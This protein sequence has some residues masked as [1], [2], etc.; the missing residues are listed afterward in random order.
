MKYRSGPLALVLLLMV[1]VAV[2]AGAAQEVP[3]GGAPADLLKLDF[4]SFKDSSEIPTWTGK[5][6]KLVVWDAFGTA[7]S[8]RI[9]SAGDVV[10]PEITRIT[11][12]S[13]DAEKSFNNAGDS[14]PVKLGKIVASGNWPHLITCPDRNQLARMIDE[15]LLWDLTDLVSQNCPNLA[16]NFPREKIAGWW[17]NSWVNGGK[18]GM[19]YGLP[20]AIQ[21]KWQPYIDA[22]LDLAKWSTLPMAKPQDPSTF[23]WVR[24]DILK[25]IFPN[26]RSVAEIEDLYVKRNGRFTRQDILDVPINSKEDFIKFLYDIKKLDVR[27]GNREVFPIFTLQG[28]IDNWALLVY[29]GGLFGWN[30]G[31]PSADANYFTYWDRKAQKVQY[32]FTQGFFKEAMRTFTQLVKDQVASPEALIDNDTQFREKLDNGMYA[33]SYAWFEPNKAVLERAG[34]PYRYRKVYLNIPQDTSRFGYTMGT[35]DDGMGVAMMVKKTVSEEDVRQILHYYDLLSSEVGWKL[36]SWGPKTAGLWEE[37]DGKRF[38]KDKDLEACM[39]YNVENERDIYYHLFRGMN[40][41]KFT[42]VDPLYPAV[43]SRWVPSV[44]YDREVKAS[45]AMND[46]ALGVPSPMK[47][48]PGT[49]PNIWLFFGA[50]PEVDRFWAARSAFEKGLIKIQTAENDAQFEQYFNEMV[51]L[52]QRNGM[53]AQT[54]EQI[55]KVYKENIN[56]AFMQNLK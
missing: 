50:V 25:R 42:N 43:N 10:W 46:F 15:G 18:S 9:K 56:A 29:L 33:I 20:T 49:G 35:M 19:I 55:D 2:F 12:V 5:Q 7:V 26:A 16:K 51:D 40:A 13:I 4:A 31:M 22:S 41:G 52:A 38:F 37:R 45:D 39:V 27:E 17:D 53:T 34:K 30:P 11:G 21:P 48:V 54:L 47:L 14:M 36:V 23:I 44:Y 8:E 3:K 32:M 24:D 6:L 28:A 1:P